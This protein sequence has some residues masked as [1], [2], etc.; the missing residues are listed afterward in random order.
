MIINLIFELLALELLLTEYLLV[1]LHQI[2]KFLL[3]LGL[4]TYISELLLELR[5]NQSL[6]SSRWAN[7]CSSI[8]EWLIA[9]WMLVISKVESLGGEG[10]N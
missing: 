7:I 10:S 2:L 9:S 4:L 5:I 3:I 6:D 8:L 1:S